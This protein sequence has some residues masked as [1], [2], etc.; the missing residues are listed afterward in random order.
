MTRL[1]AVG[2]WLWGQPTCPQCARDLRV[3]DAEPI[4]LGFAERTGLRCYDCDDVL[5]HAECPVVEGVA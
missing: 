4:S 3:I 2:F 5:A 1:L